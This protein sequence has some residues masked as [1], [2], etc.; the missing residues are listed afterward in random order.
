M[1]ET[2][3]KS[4]I[5]IG[6]TKRIVFAVLIGVLLI[7]ISVF[8]IRTIGRLRLQNKAAN[9]MNMQ[10]E[11]DVTGEEAED[12]IVYY[13]GE[14]YQYN[15]DILTFLVLGIDNAD[16]FEEDQ[17]KSLGGQ[18]DCIFLAVMD[19]KK[20]TLKLISVSRDSMTDVAIYDR[21]GNYFRTVQEHLAI[22]YAY[23]GGGKKSCDLMVNAVSNLMYGLPIHGYC[24]VNFDG[25]PVLNDAVGGVDVIV[26]E[27]LTWADLDFVQGNTV[28]LMGEQAFVYVRAR[29]IK[30]FASNNLRINRQKQYLKAL[31]DTILEQTKEDITLP[32]NIVSKLKDYMLTDISMD[33]ITYLAS[34]L[35]NYSIDL[36]NIQ[37]VP[38][39]LVHPK[40]SMYEQFII[41][42]DAL[43]EMILEVFYEKAPV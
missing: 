31:G 7:V 34:E 21:N 38:G 41:D 42:Q 14:R 3:R 25:V 29:N 1:M 22:Q 20:K 24:A 6:K 9:G 27:D 28:H 30:V 12:G 11:N 26:L 35:L 17:E 43:Y 33:Q 16:S 8:S 10:S 2:K 32:L 19:G 37:S 23:G 18:A 4:E 5:K 39:E 13:K 36:D 15:D 40:N